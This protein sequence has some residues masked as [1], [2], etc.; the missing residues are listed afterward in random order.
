MASS[1]PPAW[2][3]KHP[4]FTV[5]AIRCEKIS[6]GCAPRPATGNAAAHWY[7]HFPARVSEG[8]ALRLFR[9]AGVQG[10]CNYATAV[11]VMT[12]RD[13]VGHI[14]ILMRLI[15]RSWGGGELQSGIGKF[16]I[17]NFVRVVVLTLPLSLVFSSR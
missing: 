12:L 5:P 4:C 17:A 3:T 9:P 13:V 8:T 15:E 16:M 7:N 14:R 1:F 11:A 10:L 2:R 6:A